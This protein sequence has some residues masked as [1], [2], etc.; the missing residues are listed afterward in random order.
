MDAAMNA[1]ILDWGVASQPLPGETESGDRCV[2]EIFDTGALAVVI[3]ALGHGPEAAHAADVA[4]RVLKQNAREEPGELLHLC[5]EQMRDTRGAAISL[6]SLD[7]SRRT[8]TW[9]GIGNVAGVLVNAAS[10]NNPRVK[11]LVVHGG[12]VGYQLPDLRPLEVQ[13]AP[14]DV[15]ILATDGIR[16]DFT[17]ILPLAVNAQLLADRILDGYATRNDDALVLVFHCGGDF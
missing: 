8:M 16:A 1:T 9:L 2:V 14:G 6:A 13:V 3:D 7:W 4:T 5:H 10:E 12:V 11:Q 17:K 15:L